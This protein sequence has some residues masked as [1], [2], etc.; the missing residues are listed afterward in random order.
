ML[1]HDRFIYN[2]IDSLGM[3]VAIVWD[4]SGLQTQAM[5]KKTVNEDKNTLHSTELSNQ[6][7]TIKIALFDDSFTNIVEMPINK[8]RELIE[9]LCRDYYL[10]F[11]T[12]ENQN[13][14]FYVMF[15]EITR[16][17]I[18]VTN[19]GYLELK[20]K[21][22]SAYCASHFDI[23]NLR[24]EDELYVELP[25]K[26]DVETRPILE[27]L[28]LDDKGI[29]IKNLTNGKSIEVSTTENEVIDID[30]QGQY[31]KSNIVKN[32]YKDFNR[33]FLTLPRGINR[34]KI[35]GNCKIKFKYQHHFLI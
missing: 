24:C 14:F 19:T 3:N 30:C 11:Q 32:K 1:I 12:F 33:V 5:F 20:A 2:N 26:G 8:R 10:P 31:I 21:C 29:K 16:S 22:D 34:V 28:A 7:F 9:W 18:T 4:K 13:I 35:E 17:Y 15:S 6:E 25:N 27:V 23:Y